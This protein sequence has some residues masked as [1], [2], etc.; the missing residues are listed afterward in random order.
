M[1]L[2]PMI[3]T[4][5]KSEESEARGGSNRRLRLLLSPL[6]LLARCSDQLFLRA[7]AW[8]TMNAR[9]INIIKN[10]FLNILSFKCLLIV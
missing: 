9:R 10:K 8:K 6:C 2:H 7:A 4:L 1:S 3:T 5:R